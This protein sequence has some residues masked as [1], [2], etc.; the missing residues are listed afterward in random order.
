MYQ[1]F[2]QKWLGKRVDFD[3]AYG[4]QCVDL[5]KQYI[6]EQTGV[7]AGSWGNAIDFARKPNVQ[8]SILYVR[9]ST[10]K[11]GDIVVFNPI[12][13]LASHRNGHIGVV[14]GIS[15]GS[16]LTLEQNG[17]NGSGD[18]RGGNAIRTRYIATSR[19]AAYFTIKVSTPP[20]N[21]AKLRIYL[22]ADTTQ[23]KVYP[24]GSPNGAKSIG[25]VNPIKYAPLSYDIIRK[26]IAQG[27]YIIHTQIL[28]DV[29]I[30]QAN[31]TIR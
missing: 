14:D 27:R 13:N 26:D 20:A 29:S 15:G 11:Q 2:K 7:R 10:P 31:A 19:V 4:F 16:V 12:D 5:V 6:F 22:P 21:P 25:S 8:F 9:T 17:S 28:G 18:G 24:V 30:P 3:G 23:W 1:N